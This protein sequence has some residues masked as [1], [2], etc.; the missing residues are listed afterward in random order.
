[1]NVGFYLVQ[2]PDPTGYVLADLMLQSVRRAMPGVR[3]TQFTDIKSAAVYGVD[4]VLRKPKQP[5][6]LLRTLHQ[7]CVEGDWLFI[8]TD[9]IVRRDVRHLFE[10]PF[11]IAVADRQWQHLE[12]PPKFTAAMPWNI[13][14]VFSRGP[15]FWRA[16]HTQLL[17]SPAQAQDF[18]GDQVAACHLLKTGDW[19]LLE[20][21]GMAFNYPPSGPD[22]H[23]DQA[24]IVH[25][26]GDRKGW[27]L[28]ELRR[29]A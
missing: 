13:G 22:D 6:A 20:L 19:R 5:L 3:V 28:Q 15:R 25:Y 7:A 9:V 23:G 10:Q 2:G 14:V 29:C 27:M 21:P 1:M 24:S 11:D 16:V 17:S 12:T 8:D 26:K 4:H 18:M